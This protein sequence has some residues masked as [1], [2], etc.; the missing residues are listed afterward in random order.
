VTK[1]GANEAD[2]I[3]SEAYE[4]VECVE[5]SAAVGFLDPGKWSACFGLSYRDLCLY[6][7]ATSGRIV[8]EN[9]K[10]LRNLTGAGGI[11]QGRNK[12][13]EMFLKGTDAEWLFMVDSD[14][15]FEHDIVDR[16][17]E[18]AD[19]VDRPVVGA[20]AFCL[21][22]RDAKGGPQEMNSMYSE[23]FAIEPTMYKWAEVQ[24]TGEQGVLPMIHYRDEVKKKGTSI[25]QVAATGAAAILIHRR[26]FYDI[27]GKY[28]P[29]WYNTITHPTAGGNNT[30]RIFSEDLSFCIR[31]QSLDIPVHVDTAIKTTH[32]KGGIFLNENSFDDY[33]TL[34]KG[35]FKE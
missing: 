30:M 9:G 32:E 35:R 5:G 7:M 34:V 26:V 6:D 12:I 2:K 19:P 16:L 29:I 20:L 10:E 31:C 17:V 21:R 28:G 1:S 8:R 22:K 13:V 15:G 24:D 3:A 27:L 4:T 23:S 18:S 11:P 14:M 33:R 25:L